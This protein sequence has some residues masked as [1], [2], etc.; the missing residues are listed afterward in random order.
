MELPTVNMRVLA[1]LTLLFNPCDAFF[2]GAAPG[3]GLA[4]RSLA[5]P[6]QAQ[7]PFCARQ[8]VAVGHDGV[9]VGGWGAC[10]A[11]VVAGSWRVESCVNLHMEGRAGVG[12]GRG[13]AERGRGGAKYQPAVG[14]RDVAPTRF[15]DGRGVNRGRGGGVP[16]KGG[17]GP[18]N[19]RQITGVIKECRD[20]GVLA[21]IL[22]EQKEII[23][24]IHVSA[25]WGCLARNARGRGGGDFRAAV[26]ALQD[27]TRDAM[28]QA[29]GREIA[30]V[31]YSMSKL[32]QMGVRADPGLLETMQRRATATAGEFVPQAVSNVLWALA[33]MGERAD[34]GLLEAMQRRATATA[35]DFKPQEV[36]NLLWALATMGVRADRGLLEAMQR[37]ATAM[38][39]DFKPQE[40]ANLFWS[41]ATMGGVADRGLLQAMQRRATATA[42]ETKP[43][44]VANLLWSLATMGERADPG[45][46]EALQERATATAGEFKPQEV[47]NLLWALATMGEK[48]DQGLL[49]AMQKQATATTGKFTSQGVTILLWAILMG[50]GKLRPRKPIKHA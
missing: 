45:L 35:E 27:R 13:S 4:L 1:L 34:R 46:P 9:A 40:V 15:S 21:R 12:G 30:N 2:H 38:A 32:H 47:A 16:A 43:Q 50:L 33:T 19:A 26:A 44:E 18:L 7:Q 39:V 37:R 24:H 49:E 41:L 20:V 3:S 28:G 36:A 14:R 42:G 25:A 31:I 29:G 10:Q 17:G 5:S 6:A 8:L 23:N 48:S 11:Q 22:Q